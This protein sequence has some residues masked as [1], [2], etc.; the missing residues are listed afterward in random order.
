VLRA[1]R[2]LL[3]PGGRIALTTIYVT[4][5]LDAR[6]RRRANRSGPRAVASRSGQ[7]DLLA[8]AGFVGVDVIDV[9][10]DFARTARAWLAEMDAHAEQIAALEGR[11]AFEERQQERRTQ[12][13]AI[14][15]GLLRRGL[16]SAT[17]PG[18]R[19]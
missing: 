17:S 19:R 1:L 15:D 9:T 12:L 13:A 16:L 5:G 6:L 11:A 18:S 14:D 3:R 7:A 4:P 8:S 10:A 2:K